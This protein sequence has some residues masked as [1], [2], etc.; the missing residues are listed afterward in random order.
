MYDCTGTHTH[1]PHNL[2]TK[3]TINT[4]SHTCKQLTHFIHMHTHMHIH[5]HTHTSYTHTHTLHTHAHTHAHTHTRTNTHTHTHT[6]TLT[7]ASCFFIETSIAY[8]GKGGQLTIKRPSV[9]E[10]QLNED[11]QN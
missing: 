8:S 5:T 7:L 9:R 2:H 3:T 6:R 1:T 11:V 10:V 4:L